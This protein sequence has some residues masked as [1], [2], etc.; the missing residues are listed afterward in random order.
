M[1]TLASRIFHLGE[2][3]RL[4]KRDLAWAFHQIPV[5]PGDI[6]FLGVTWGNQVYFNT[7]LPMGLTLATYICQRITNAVSWIM[8][9]R[10]YW[11][12]NY[13]DD[14]TGAEKGDRAI[15]AFHLLYEVLQDIGLQE[16]CE[17]MEEPG[18]EREVLGI[19]FNTCDMTISL[20]EAKV[21]QALLHIAD[22]L[23]RESITLKQ[24][25]EL[26]GQLHF[27]T[28]CIR[29]G[30]VFMN[31]ILNQLRGIEGRNDIVV[32][33]DFR[34]DLQWWH[35]F[36]PH[37]NGTQPMWLE[38]DEADAFLATDTTLIGMGAVCQTEYLQETFPGFL[39]S[40]GIFHKELWAVIVA[41]KTWS[42]LIQGRKL[43]LLTDNT[44]VL[45][46]INRG[47]TSDDL[48]QNMLREVV[49]LCVQKSAWLK[50]KYVASHDNTLPDLLSRWHEGNETQQKFARLTDGQHYKQVHLKGDEY[51]LTHLT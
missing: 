7:M 9:K 5:D 13:I 47:R 43:V 14:F 8:A 28:K 19:V 41:L 30:R 35:R 48:A 39:E 23:P 6:P 50:M 45:E 16:S 31:K 34:Q 49:W 46:V 40:Q 37:I 2:G 15:V 24:C 44:A 51:M 36:M 10:G 3:T 38:F 12:M 27:L 33:G 21:Q 32:T 17:K 22:V 29:G 25:Q 18:E 42:H 26:V 11:V 1:D 4:Y 20:P